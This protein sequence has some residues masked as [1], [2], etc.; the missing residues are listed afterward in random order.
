ML[1]SLHNYGGGVVW[2]RDRA[3]SPSGFAP[4]WLRRAQLENSQCI[5]WFMVPCGKHNTESEKIPIDMEKL[6]D[7]SETYVKTYAFSII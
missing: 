5:S 4:F 6:Q 7:H 1:R 2:V 3:I